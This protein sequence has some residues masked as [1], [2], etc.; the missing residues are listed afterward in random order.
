[1][2]VERIVKTAGFTESST[3]DEKHRLLSYLKEDTVLQ[4]LLMNLTLH[5][6]IM[7]HVMEHVMH[8]T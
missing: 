8:Q 4:K 6:Y 3:V 5:L 7:E 2:G 1:M